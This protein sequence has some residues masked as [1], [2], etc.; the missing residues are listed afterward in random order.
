MYT[1]KLMLVLAVVFISSL[2]AKELKKDFNHTFNV[3]EGTVLILENGDGNVVIQTWDKDQIQVDVSYHADIRSS[4]ENDVEDFKVDFKQDGKSVYITGKEYRQSWSGYYS[5]NHIE[6]TYKIFLPSYTELEIYSDDGNIEIENL[7]ANI[8]CRTDDGNL[9]LINITN[10]N[11]NLK[12]KDGDVRISSLNGNLEIRCDDGN[13]VLEDV[14]VDEA[15]ISASDGRIRIRNSS[16]DF[17]VDSDDGDINLTQVSGK[18]LDVRT[19]DGD[20]D[21]V[22]NGTNLEDLVVSTKDGRV[23]LQLDEKISAQFL[24]ETNDGHIRFDLNEAEIISENKRRIRGELGSGAGN[25]RIKTG[26]GSISMRD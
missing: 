1:S 22:Y 9:D 10:E 21:I 24:L 15:E 11:T 3:S 14:T 25:I 26:D 20:V 8:K 6:Y 7:K 5:I 19:K 12:L 13:I 2:N 18:K 23:T 17:F 16:G 4:R